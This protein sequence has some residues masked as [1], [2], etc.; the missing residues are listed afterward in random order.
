MAAQRCCSP[1]IPGRRTALRLLVGELSA[2][3]GETAQASA[4]CIEAFEVACQEGL[5][6]EAAHSLHLRAE[7]DARQGQLSSV[8]ALCEQAQVHADGG[9]PS[10]RGSLALLRGQLALAEEQEEAA[11][12]Y[13]L[14]AQIFAEPGPP[15]S[16]ADALLARAHCALARIYEVSHHLE[17]SFFTGRLPTRQVIGEGSDERKE[18]CE[19]EMLRQVPV[20]RAVKEAA[21]ET[22]SVETR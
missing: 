1:P 15:A 9:A 10:R 6:D 22:G 12:W 21:R 7:L 5:H 17:Q 20:S 3:L 14:A 2:G 19:Q 11:C 4:L 16:E 8:R 18:V 13:L